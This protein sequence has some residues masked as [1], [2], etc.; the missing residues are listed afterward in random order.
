MATHTLFVKVEPPSTEGGAGAASRELTLTVLRYIKANL[1]QI[2]AMGI[3]VRVQKVREDDLKNAHAI[4][5]MQERGI[6]RLPT[7]CT[8]QQVY[9][10]AKS[11]IGLYEKNISAYSERQRPPPPVKEKL[12]PDVDTYMSQQM[13]GGDDEDDDGMSEGGSNMMDEYRQ[14]ISRRDG[15]G[16]VAGPPRQHTPQRA[17]K[18]EGNGGGRPQMRPNNVATR[19]P[20]PRSAPQQMGRPSTA[21]GPSPSA[22][23]SASPSASNAPPGFDDD[24]ENSPQDDLM[25]RAY[26]AN[27]D[28]SLPSADDDSRSIED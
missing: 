18:D 13:M 25:E 4:K 21:S 12:T 1:S 9:T 7:L 23:H 3:T 20:A 6:S 15:S 2:K 28:D 10:G 27:M 16:G 17:Q 24:D 5:M 11:I 14:V 22:L 26:L 19:A 8:P